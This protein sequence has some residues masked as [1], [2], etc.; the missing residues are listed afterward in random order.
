MATGPKSAWGGKRPGAGRP[1]NTLNAQQVDNMLTAAEKKAEEKGK[2]IDEILLGFIY[3]E[4]NT[5]SERR[6]CIKVWKEYTMARLSEGGD[7]DK[8]LGPQVYLPEERPDSTKV[9][10]IKQTG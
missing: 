6:Q 10:P 5:K 1:V 4:N 7:T 2:T 8:Q 9:V 3:D